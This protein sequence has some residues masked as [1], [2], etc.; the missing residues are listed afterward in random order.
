MR[1]VGFISQND[2]GRCAFVLPYNMY[3]T[4]DNASMVGMAQWASAGKEG[5]WAEGESFTCGG[6]LRWW[7]ALRLRWWVANLLH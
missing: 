4:S 1:D 5:E 3:D 2:A 7:V 6:D